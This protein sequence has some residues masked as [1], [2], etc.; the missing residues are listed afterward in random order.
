MI[1]PI[2][3]VVEGGE[4][5]FANLERLLILALKVDGGHLASVRAWLLDSDQIPGHTQLRC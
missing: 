1:D 5:I 3:S 2:G 4:I